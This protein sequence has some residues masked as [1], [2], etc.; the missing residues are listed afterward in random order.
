MPVAEFLKPQYWCA[1]GIGA[2]IGSTGLFES[3]R[4]MGGNTNYAFEIGL[5]IG[6]LIGVFLLYSANDKHYRIS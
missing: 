2:L 3:I 6:A 5:P 1:G 4:A